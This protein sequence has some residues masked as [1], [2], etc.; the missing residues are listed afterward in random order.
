MSIENELRAETDSPPLFNYLQDL[1]PLED[2]RDFA[3][4]KR[5]GSI[6]FVKGFAIVFIIL[7]HFWQKWDFKYSFEWIVREFS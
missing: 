3:S 2:I 1:I 7:A 4:P 5:I 6:D